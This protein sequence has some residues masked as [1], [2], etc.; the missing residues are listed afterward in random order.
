MDFINSP[1]FFS[2]L[3]LVAGYFAVRVL[4]KDAA[5]IHVLVNQRLD[6]TLS[7]VEALQSE[8]ETLGGAKAPPTREESRNAADRFRN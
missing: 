1:V 5:G 4:R 6:D 8:V 7:K 3:L 2:L